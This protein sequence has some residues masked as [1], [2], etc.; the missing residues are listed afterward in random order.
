MTSMF[1]VAVR[2]HTR[3]RV[4]ICSTRAAI[5]MKALPI[6]SKVATRH[7]DFFGAAFLSRSMSQ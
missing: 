1:D 3:M 2:N 6:V 4:F 5:L 7:L